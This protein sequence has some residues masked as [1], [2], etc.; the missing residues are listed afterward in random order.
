LKTIEPTVSHVLICDSIRVEDSKKEVLVGVY[1]GM[2]VINHVPTAL[3]SFAIRLEFWPGQKKDG[4]FKIEIVS[5]KGLPLIAGTSDW[6]VK[7]GHDHRWPGILFV[8]TGPLPLPEFGVYKIR[9]AFGE[10]QP[11]V[12]YK[13][14]V[15][16]SREGD[17]NYQHAEQVEAAGKSRGKTAR[18]KK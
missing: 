11:R 5:P 7:E 10:R 12:V 6:H 9:F 4:K 3:A 8:Q 15:R 18:K 17:P 14:L 2:L 1:H 16:Q 13:F